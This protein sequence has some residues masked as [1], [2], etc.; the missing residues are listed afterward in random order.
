[1]VFSACRAGANLVLAGR[2]DEF[3]ASPETIYNINYFAVSD[4][5]WKKALAVNKPTAGRGKNKK[6]PKQVETEYLSMYPGYGQTV[7]EL[8]AFF[9]AFYGL[10]KYMENVKSVHQEPY[11]EEL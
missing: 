11:A 8:D 2:V 6:T 10:R 9:L 3:F 1:M 4:A 5:E 7:H